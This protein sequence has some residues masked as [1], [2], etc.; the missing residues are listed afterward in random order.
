M[1]K[2]KLIVNADDYG[3]TL[4]T[5]RGIERGH[6]EGLVTSTTVM[7]NQAAVA[8][9]AELHACC[10]AL[11]VGIH[12]TLTLGPPTAPTDA[13]RS[14]LDAEGQ[15]L[16]RVSLLQ[17]LQRGE[18]NPSE[19]MAECAAQVRALRAL[20]L[21]PDHWDVHQHLQEYAALGRPIAAAMLAEGVLHARNPRRARVSWDQWRPKAII[22]ARRRAAMADLVG[23]DFTAPDFL[24]EASPSRWGH[25][26]PL[27]PN[28][29]IEA[30]CHPGEPDGALPESTIDTAERVAELSVLCDRTLGDRLAERGVQLATFKDAFA[31]ERS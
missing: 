3:I 10:P 2:L 11:G 9:A 16:G 7:A 22:Q 24:F 14:L 1:L 13:V 17:R 5:N 6:L 25:L 21:D 30:I 4:A 15:L 12:V 29:V 19:V 23:D 8:D 26:I 31:V 18:V 27:L 20:G 28:G